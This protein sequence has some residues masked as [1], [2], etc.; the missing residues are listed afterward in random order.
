MYLQL[1]CG[2]SYFGVCLL[3]ITNMIMGYCFEVL[4]QLLA[5]IIL[6]YFRCISETGQMVS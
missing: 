1:M 5:V 4:A 3:K 2:T 6:V